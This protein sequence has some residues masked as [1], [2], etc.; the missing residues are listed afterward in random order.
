[1][2]KQYTA[3]E[4]RRDTGKW[5]DEMLIAVGRDLHEGRTVDSIVEGDDR[6]DES[7]SYDD[8]IGIRYRALDVV[9]EGYR[10]IAKPRRIG[11]DEVSGYAKPSCKRCHGLG[12][13]NVRRRAEHS[14]DEIGRKVM[15][16]V[17]YVQT[18]GCADKRYKERNRLFLIDSQLGEWIHLHDLVICEPGGDDATM[19]EVLATDHDLQLRGDAGVQ[20]V[21][22]EGT[23]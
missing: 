12:R 1:M 22:G 19:P 13:F 14:K 16:D 17:E 8:Q 5:S 21:P 11:T 7:M 2:T 20:R 10:I 9:V 15:Q 23:D 4:L 18:C 6:Y 3:D